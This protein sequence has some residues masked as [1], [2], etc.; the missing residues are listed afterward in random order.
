[1]GKKFQNS[2]SGKQLPSQELQA[3]QKTRFVKSGRSG[4]ILQV[5]S[6][7]RKLNINDLKAEDL[8][9]Q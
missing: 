7:I 5:Q 8:K 9:G 3:S 6:L 4:K 2:K 1:M